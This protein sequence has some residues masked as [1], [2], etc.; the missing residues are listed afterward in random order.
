MRRPKREVDGRLLW[1]HGDARVGVDGSTC[2]LESDGGW[3][4]ASA[5]AD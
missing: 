1:V 5:A 2:R 4:G 3:G